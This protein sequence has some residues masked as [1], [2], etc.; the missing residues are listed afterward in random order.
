MKTAKHIIDSYF[1]NECNYQCV[2]KLYSAEPHKCI[3]QTIR[4]RISSYSFDYHQHLHFKY[5][6]E[7]LENT[8]VVPYK[9]KRHTLFFFSEYSKR[10]WKIFANNLFAYIILVPRRR[11]S[12]V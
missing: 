2:N 11:N 12:I 6:L 10:T 7:L 9:W 8:A 3:Y 5:V 1:L 4:V